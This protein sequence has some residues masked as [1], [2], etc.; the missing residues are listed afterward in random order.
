MVMAPASWYSLVLAVPG[1][2]A[3]PLTVIRVDAE[4]YG[5]WA[6]RALLGLSPG[7]PSPAPA[8]VIARQSA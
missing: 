6:A 5:R 7:D 8:Q 3:W 4:G 2:T 1:G